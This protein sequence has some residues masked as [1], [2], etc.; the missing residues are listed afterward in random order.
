M[1][2]LEITDDCLVPDRFIYVTYEGKDPWGVANLISHDSAKKFFHVSSAG[3]NEV[4][5]KWDI[6]G[7][8]I[9]FYSYRWVKK[10]FSRF[11][12][13]E[14]WIKVQGYKYKTTNTGKF[15][16]Q[17]NAYL[18]TR[19]TGW[20]LFLKPI[21]NIYSYLFYDR[22]RRRYLE[23]C[24]EF[25]LGFQQEIRRHFNLKVTVPPGRHSSYG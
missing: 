21:W 13:M 18:H 10:S 1:G 9:T 19:F 3:T 23:Q 15:T 4:D 24:R 7:D 6:S 12:R 11:T 16:M 25:T 20:G 5:L 22:I 17:L 8:P 14:V 2:K